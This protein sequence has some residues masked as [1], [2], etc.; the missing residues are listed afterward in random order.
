MWAH[1]CGPTAVGP[2]LWPTTMGPHVGPYG[3][4]AVGPHTGPSH[5]SDTHILIFRS[6]RNELFLSCSPRSLSSYQVHQYGKTGLLCSDTS[7]AHAPSNGQ[8]V[9]HFW[10]ISNSSCDAICHAMDKLHCF[11]LHKKQTYNHEIAINTQ[12]AYPQNQ[13]ARVV[14]EVDLRSPGGNSTWVQT[15]QLTII[16]T[17]IHLA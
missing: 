15:P 9:R 2:Q 13:F 8:P 4:T 6:Y 11:V 17:H 1:G 3:P 12:C 7:P 14:K 16:S 5:H 10:V